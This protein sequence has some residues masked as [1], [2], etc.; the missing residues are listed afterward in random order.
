MTDMIDVRHLRLELDGSRILDDVS[1]VIEKG[2]RWA[3]VGP[4]GAGKS[5]LLKCLSRIHR[6]WQGRITIDGVDARGYTNRELA[7]LVAYVPQ[8]GGRLPPFTVRETIVMS[9]YPHL[10]HFGTL[11]PADHSLVKDVL[12]RTGLGPLADRPM[13]TLSG[14]ERQKVFLASALAQGAPILLLDEPTTFLDP[15]HAHDLRSLIHTLNREEGVTVI[16]ATHDLNA[17]VLDADRIF[18]L[19]D[20]RTH[21]FGPPDSFYDPEV[22]RMLYDRSFLLGEHP[23]TGQPMILPGRCGDEA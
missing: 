20:G 2:Q 9:R 17:A 1:F 22:L 3:L 21:F 18:A 11:G 15:R 8:A 10:S 14:G 16:E 4:N 23:E 19:R 13:A 5:S 7:R 12:A 6:D